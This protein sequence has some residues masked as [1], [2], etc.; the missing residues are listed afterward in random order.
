MSEPTTN[1]RIELVRPL[2]F[3]LLEDA[4]DLP[5]V[6]MASPLGEVVALSVRVSPAPDATLLDALAR[7]AAR[8]VQVSDSLFDSVDYLAVAHT[9]ACT[10]RFLCAPLGSPPVVVFA[11]DRG[12]GAVGPAVAERLSLPHLGAVYAVELSRDHLLVDRQLGP[13]VQRL[14]GTPPVVLACVLAPE[15][16][17][18]PAA[19]PGKAIEPLDL[20]ALH[21]T[22]QE[23]LHRRRFRPTE[24][25]APAGRP[26]VLASVE[27]L[28][29]RLAR[30]GVWPQRRSGK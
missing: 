19:A 11:G 16:R 21:I 3:V 1:P 30:D 24:G 14:R 26:R 8:A 28:T 18:A 15:A 7:G 12:R 17:A 23:L 9:L 2:I 13:G 22:S 27:R 4:R 20:E 25:P 5:L 29:D 6:G 10:V